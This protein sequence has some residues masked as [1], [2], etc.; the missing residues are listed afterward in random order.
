[1]VNSRAIQEVIEVGA[2]SATV[3]AGIYIQEVVEVGGPVAKLSRAFQE[4]IEVGHKN[5]P[6]PFTSPCSPWMQESL[7]H[8]GHRLATLWTITRRDGQVFRFTDHCG[9]LV[10][11]VGGTFTPVGGP[12]ASAREHEAGDREHTAEMKA[13]LVVGGA[14]TDDLEAGK[15][16]DAIAIERV[17]DWRHPW[18]G[19][20]RYHKWFLGNIQWDGEKW[21]ATLAGYT[22]R[23]RRPQGDIYSQHSCTHDFGDAFGLDTWGCKFDV[24]ATEE[25][26]TVAAII[27]PKR[28]FR[29][30]G[31]TPA[32]AAE[33]FVGGTLTWATGDNADIVSVVRRQ[34]EG[35]GYYEFELELP[36]PEAVAIGDTF[37]VIKGCQKRFLE[38][39]TPNAQTDNFGGFPHMP[40]PHGIQ[41]DIHP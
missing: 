15:W 17:V 35:S 27:S 9:A 24:A 19:C 28:I 38:D 40:G 30:T 21:T 20:I 3:G 23:F 31:L 25:T 1:M 22:S 11:D 6:C 14:E 13:A 10:D 26:G 39:C 2:A 16:H 7:S 33:F 36:P 18:M 32:L 41:G 4:V 8:K 29:A 37:D 34:T 12:G 5:N